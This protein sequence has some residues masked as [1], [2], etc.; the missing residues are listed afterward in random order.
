M[1]GERQGIS[2]SEVALKPCGLHIVDD[3]AAAAADSDAYS[4][5][6]SDA[7]ASAPACW[8]WL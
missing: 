8:S 3:D 6:D 4:D 7:V 1:D 2:V 5:A